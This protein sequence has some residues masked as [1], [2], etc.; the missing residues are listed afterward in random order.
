MGRPKYLE[1]ILNK[2]LVHTPK[3]RLITLSVMIIGNLI[4]NET[5]QT[6]VNPTR[7]LL[8][9]SERHHQWV[10][11]KAE[12]GHIV[13]AFLTFPEIKEKAT[14]VIVIHE[15]R[16]LT[17]WVRLVGD[18]LAKHG[19][20]AVCPDLLS[21]E[22]SEGGGTTSFSSSDDA[23][24]AI[25]DLSSDQVTA[26]LKAVTEY[27]H[28]LTS[29]TGKVV[30]TGFCWGGAQAFRFAT[31]E[32]SIAAVCVFYGRPPRKEKID[33]INCP[34]YGFYGENDERINSTIK[35]TQN[36]AGAAGIIY[37]PVIYAGVGHA[38]LRRGMEPN[39]DEV[40]QAAN[41]QAWERLLKLLNKL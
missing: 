12:N 35:D 15:N 31:N 30:V 7:D 24:R 37:E 39:A 17:D 16:G 21:G 28:N 11:I 5:G 3:V 19:F 14:A 32:N 26:D 13:N 38:F 4:M 29:T 41:R 1:N 22:G 27:V 9:K 36:A 23:R 2:L 18:Q 6:Q 33:R 25:Y 20:V 34:V 8:A 10:K 40:E